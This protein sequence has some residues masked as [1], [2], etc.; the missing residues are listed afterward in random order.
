MAASVSVAIVTAASVAAKPVYAQ[1]ETDRCPRSAALQTGTTDGPYYST[2]S[3][4]EHFDSS[5]TQLFSDACSLGEIKGRRIRARS[6]TVNF[7]TPYIAFT[8]DRGEIFVYGY[9]EDA[10]TE[11]GFVASVDTATLQ[12]NWRTQIIADELPNQWSYPGVGLVHG[13]GFIYAIYANVLVK[14]DPA[15][16]SILKQL[17]LPEDL[18]ETGAAY[19]G[20]IVMPDG[21]IVAKGMERGPCK[22]LPGESASAEAFEGLLCGTHNQLPSTIVTVDPDDLSI[23]QEVTPPEPSTGRLTAGQTDGVNYVYVAGSSDMF[24]YIYSSGQ[25]T[26]DNS[27]GPVTYRTGNQQ[28]GTGPGI[29]GDYVVIQTNFLPAVLGPMTV[30]AANVRD[31]SKTFSVRPFPDSVLSWNVSKMALDA[32]NDMIVTNDTAA[33]KMAGV[34]LDPIG[35]LRIKWRRDETTLDFSALVGGPKDRNVV[36]P[37]FTSKSGDRTIWIDEATGKTKAESQIL[38]SQPAPGNI[39]TPGFD[40]K[41]YYISAEGQLWELTVGK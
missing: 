18:D 12:Q 11:G 38:S 22:T 7:A 24:R 33:G 36:V 4:F 23:I 8:R 21:V 31:S 39:V 37:N 9:G 29:L 41:F 40:G 34:S 5:R 20:M 3:P 25:L 28:P 16:G 32:D 27:W 19:N 15:T 13:N 14:L 2:I 17:V 1:P 6:S 26:L 30:T 10:A 35:G